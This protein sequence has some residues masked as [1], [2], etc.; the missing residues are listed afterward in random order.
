MDAGQRR[1]AIMNRRIV[2][3]MNQRDVESALGKPDAIKIRNSSTRYT[4]K[5]KKGRSAEVVFDEKGCVKAKS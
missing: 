2:A 1:E 5:A 3:G 4:Y